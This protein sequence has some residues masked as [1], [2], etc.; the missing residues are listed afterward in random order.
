MLNAGGAEGPTP[1]GTRLFDAT[2]ALLHLAQIQNIQG[3]A[4]S[5]SDAA[6]AVRAGLLARGR[7]LLGSELGF[8]NFLLHTMAATDVED[9]GAVGA[10]A[11]EARL[12][13]S[14]GRFG[15]KGP[16][17]V[18]IEAFVPRGA[19][20]PLIV[21]VTSPDSP[22]LVDSVLGALRARG[23]TVRLVSHP[24]LPVDPI[25][26]P[27]RV[28]ATTQTDA[29]RVSF[30]HIEAD[31][32]GDAEANANLKTEIAAT[33]ADVRSAVTAWRPMLERLHRAVQ[34]LRRAEGTVDAAHLSE[35][36][37][38]LGWLADAN[39]V[40]LGMREYRLRDGDIE[41]VA[42][43]GL[44][45]MRDPAVKVLRAG[46]EPAESTP[47][48]RAFLAGPEL[49]RVM[50]ANFRTRVHRRSH[51][52][53]V[54]IKLFD[55]D[56]R[57]SGELRLVGLFT[58]QS[59]TTPNAEV[60]LLRRKLGRV[61][62]ASGLDAEGH[63]GKALTAALSSYPRD[64]L[65]QVDAELLG[66]HAA[67]IAQLPDRP[68]VRVLAR[69]DPSGNY[70]S[71]LLYMPRDNYDSTVR[72]RVGAILADRYGGRLS[73]FYPSFPDDALV[74][75]HFIIGRDGGEV[76]DVDRAALEAEI[77]GLSQS[78]ADRL[79]RS[80]AG[81]L[82]VADYRGAF[83]PGYEA[84][85]T[86]ETA[87]GDIAVLR[88]LSEAQRFAVRLLPRQGNELGLRIYHFGGP[89]PLSNRV[90][91]LEH[92]GFRVIEEDTEA[93]TPRGGATL[94]VHDMVVATA[95]PLDLKSLGTLIEAALVAVW[96]GEADDDAYNRLIAAARLAWDDVA[97]LRA[98]GRYLAQAGIAYS[99][100]Y[101]A[102]TLAAHAPAASALVRLFHATLDP[103]VGGDR[104]ALATEARG[105]VAAALEQTTTIDEE[106]ILGRF[107]NLVDAAVRSNHAQRGPGNKRRPALAI[108]FE[109]TRIDGLPEPRPFRE[110]FVTSPRVEG[111]HL[112][113]G[114]IARGGIRWS[115]RPEDFRT[116]ILGLAKAQQVKNA[117]IVPEGA[118]GG[119][120]LRALPKGADRETT[121]RVGRECYEIFIGAL[122][123]ITDDLRG[124][125]IVPPAGVLRRD[126]DDPYLVVAAD[127]GTAS[128]SDVANAI[129]LS[130]GFWLGDAFASGGSSG[131]DHKKMGITARGA[132]ESVKR[133]FRELGRDIHSEP[134]TVAGVGDMS[135][136]VFGNGM[137]LEK[138]IRLVAA[139]DHRHIFLDPDPD[140]AASHLARRKLFERERSSWDD[141]DKSV[142]SKGGG[143]FARNAKLIALS[144][145]AGKALGVTA[146]TI[147]PD[148]LVT[149]IL[150]AE[151]DLMWFGGIGT[152]VRASTESNADAGDRAND[153]V[154]IT[155]S[156]LRAKVVGEGANL[157]MTQA[158]RIEYARAGG[159]LNTDAIDNSAGV[160]SSDLEVNIKIALGGLMKTGVLSE[161]AR[162][163]LLAEMTGEVAELCLR[164]NYLQTLAISLGQRRGANE[165]P[166]LAELMRD[167]EGR[168]LLDR[169][170]DG[171]PDETAMSERLAARQAFTRPELSVL[172]A[173]A[174]NA[175]RAELL[176]SGVPD[177][178]YLSRDLLRY[179]PAT[180]VS[181]HREMIET[182]RLRREIIATVL[183]NGIVNRGGPALALR[184]Q[185]AAS[186]SPARVA[187]AFAAARDSFGMI[188]ILGLID[189]LDGVVPAAAQLELYAD[190]E[191]ILADRAL[192][193]LRHA[194]LDAGL[195]AT[196]T[197]HTKAVTELRGAMPSLVTPELKLLL[198]GRAARMQ[199]LGA[200]RDFA[201]RLA[202]LAALTLA[203]DAV[204]VADRQS[205]S[206]ADAA[207]AIYAVIERFK[208]GPMVTGGGLPGLTD[209]F[210]RRALDRARANLFRAVRDIAADSLA[211]GTGPV[212]VRLAAWHRAR[213]ADIDG[214][215]SEVAAL[216]GGELSLSRLSI[217]GGLMSDLAR[218]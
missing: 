65:F 100:T 167:L 11:F 94:F 204:L 164:N 194:Q 145:E 71:V 39:F 32:L 80:A 131:Y 57:V 28:L 157:A 141:Y 172:L 218:Q 70:V 8:A 126:G 36:L 216:L 97:V 37:E 173:H 13:D 93:V 33:L 62:E 109:G 158:A 87:L 136:D 16:D 217:A 200:S 115:D 180:L 79:T 99:H 186:A 214:I 81:H 4:M 197:R 151:V 171:L 195:E 3:S 206:V 162:N 129:A 59:L 184:L 190:V 74:R 22:F 92:F 23:G 114:P 91:M 118:K 55:A 139:F 89:I 78:F 152:F 130:R 144:A 134:F 34:D 178:P 7:E 69:P 105:V 64:E 207:T 127:K 192:W 38:F 88:G 189:R 213:A 133:H 61:I 148:A 120:V 146:K 193:F 41:P 203:N 169:A 106:R 177:D 125:H 215:A 73:A 208:L 54:G 166:D 72:A 50:K 154:R 49:V 103:S 10:T 170:L 53:Y 187:A 24:V 86:I 153:A 196:V 63:A 156:A 29:A 95:A 52:D 124:E 85:T 48:Q 165:L 83:T 123:D 160:N 191:A 188:E 96:H 209:R 45:L 15:N 147:A 159:R 12:R 75:V 18:V 199:E 202:D 101:L 211:A 185:Q 76:P 181:K 20:A 58:S 68:R 77:A 168:G 128:F 116:E 140:P 155:A 107:L 5:T 21:D 111:V 14:F 31:P 6:E 66:R 98:L 47:A 138:T 43:S 35:A 30:I 84:G 161:R 17:T 121:A 44:G 1:A 163:A 119:F 174:K 108:K 137:L 212:P 110:I 51:M 112:R 175:L 183:A 2:A 26:R 142:I 122:L 42:E 179:F 201:R 149:A 205:V 60:P 135:G 40:F 113:F 102:T 56:F 176:G 132:W 117:V 143:V 9:L 198:N 67:V 104:Q 46:K 90:P 25:T 150:Q 19:T 210:D 182:H 27:M 82:D